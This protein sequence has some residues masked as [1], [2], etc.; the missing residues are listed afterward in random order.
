MSRILVIDDDE[1]IRQYLV[2]HLE[3]VGYETD[4]AENGLLGIEAAIQTIP[5]LVLLDIDMPVLGG[6]ETLKKFKSSES[7]RSVPV[8]MVTSFGEKKD[9][10]TALKHGANDYVIKPFDMGVLLGKLTGW[11]NTA[12]ENNWGSI[13]PAVGHALRLVKAAVENSFIA[14]RKSEALPI[15]EVRM[16]VEALYEAIETAGA[17]G[18]FRAVE[19]Y[20]SNLFLHSLLVGTYMMLYWKS[21]GRDKADIITIGMGGLLHDI[22]SSLLP[23]TI[24]FKPDKL[25]PGEFEKVKQHVVH[26]ALIMD[27]TPDVPQAVKDMCLQHHER[28]D[29]SGYPNGLEGDAISVEARTL[30]I[31]ETFAALTNTT[32]YRDALDMKMAFI[33]MQLR[34]LQFDKKIM[35]SFSEAITGGFVVQE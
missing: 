35:H 23:E 33:E 10:L 17:F 22:G 5:D 9:V 16:A 6:I 27:R 24:T 7:L 1:T 11:L 4:S 15:D 13:N 32:V 12:V 14:A 3:R 2:R 18:V 34:E 29:G 30:A 25:D 20:K 31:V 19:A 26:G 28:M 21:I 8:V